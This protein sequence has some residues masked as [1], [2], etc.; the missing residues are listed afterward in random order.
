MGLGAHP[1]LCCCCCAARAAASQLHPGPSAGE[2][3]GAWLLGILKSLG[4][5][6]FPLGSPASGD[7][8]ILLGSP[9]QIPRDSQLVGELSSSCGLPTSW[10]SPPFQGCSA[11][12][13]ILTSW[14]SPN[15]EGAQL[16][17]GPQFLRMPRSAPQNICRSPGMLSILGRS[18]APRDL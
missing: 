18:P 7:R 15:P 3:W 10:R 13:W 1:S 9:A 2:N 16:H 17:E 8:Q 6:Q 11:P 5:H 4:D 12:W 14:G